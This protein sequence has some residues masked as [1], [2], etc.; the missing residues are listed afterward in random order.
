MNPMKQQDST[1]DRNPADRT[2]R[3]STLLSADENEQVFS[4]LGR[5]CQTMCTAV[6]QV[7]QTEGTSHSIWKKK[8]T[9]ALCFVRD[10][11]KRSYFMRMYCLLKNELVWEHE[12]YDSVNITKAR[13][14]LLTFEGQDGNVGL[15]FASEGEC[16]SYYKIAVTM[17]ERSRKRQERRVRSR[18]QAAAP[19]TAQPV[20][21]EEQTKVTLRN[22][23]QIS[24]VSITPSANTSPL[25]PLGNVDK[26]SKKRGRKF[27]KSD[28]SNPTNFIHVSHV[29]WNAQK[30]FDMV[31]SEDDEMLKNFFTKA[32]VSDKELKDRATRDFIYDFVKNHDVLA[33]VKSERVEKSRAPAPPPVPTRHPAQQTTQNGSQRSAPP[34][35]PARQ[36]PPPLPT[37][38]PPTRG[39]PPS[40]PPPISGSNTS[41]ASP[42]S[43]PPPPPPPP[44]APQLA[45]VPPPPAMPQKPLT[46]D[47][48]S[49]SLPVLSPNDPRNALMESIRKGTT[50]KKVDQSALSTGSGDSRS[51]LMS[52]IRQGIELRPVESRE[53]P[54]ASNRSSENSG[55][56]ALADALRRALQ[57]RG[58]AIHSSDD[59]SDE[60]SDND[61][62]WED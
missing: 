22:H 25:K 28:I 36:P 7:Y 4:L 6:A 39:P 21:T 51:D 8:H 59:D 18:G 60:S 42:A 32:G 13:P 23:P 24:S 43:V 58:R 33:S 12:I 44:P 54:P 61:G 20:E 30:G 41:F 14:Y 17:E 34:P 40:R 2:N 3:P 16:D 53:L 56:D 62:E 52:E 46:D 37:T 31:G 57:D 15:N 1:R 35:P 27:T 48:G 38:T 11:S 49:S 55:T 5:K 47:S 45:V 19:S 10:S 29:G 9:G 50:L 26:K